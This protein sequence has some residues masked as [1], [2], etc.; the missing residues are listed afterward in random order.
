MQEISTALNFSGVPEPSERAR[1]RASAENSGIGT[2]ADAAPRENGQTAFFHLFLSVISQKNCINPARKATT[3]YRD[4]SIFR[5]V[6]RGG[7][8]I[9]S[10]PDSAIF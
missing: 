3:F 8:G 2:A 5:F 10:A 4:T 1:T 6:I 7:C 9:L